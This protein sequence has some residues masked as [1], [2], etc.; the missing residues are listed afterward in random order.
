MSII[1]VGDWVRTIKAGIWQVYRIDEFYCINPMTEKV[2]DK[3]LVFIKRFVNDSGKRSF[4]Q[5]VYSPE[6]LCK[7][8]SEELEDLSG[9]I[10]KNKEMYSKFSSY[11]PKPIDSLYAISF[12]I[13]EDKTAKEI[14]DLMP[15]DK[16]FT[17]TEIKEIVDS[18]GYDTKSYPQ[19][20]VQFLSKGT[21]LID[22]YVRYK[23]NQVLEF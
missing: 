12:A 23:F 4:T 8:D 7:L 19:W 18:L 14:S 11:K 5:T 6:V 20:R 21:E 2:E 1:K 3:T 10:D 16:S 22:G 9:F 13:P 17:Q 15:K